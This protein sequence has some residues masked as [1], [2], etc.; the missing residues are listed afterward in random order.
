MNLIQIALFLSL[1]RLS[2]CKSLWDDEDSACQ[3]P[4]LR[5]SHIN[6]YGESRYMKVF[7][8]IHEDRTQFDLNVLLKQELGSNFLIFNMKVRVRPQ[9]GANFVTLLQMKRLDLCGF[10]TDFSGNPMIRYFL[11][12][13]MQMSKIISCPVRVGNFSVAN[14]SV[15]DIYPANLQNATYKFFVDVVEGTGEI[16]KV[17]ALQVTTDISVP[18]CRLAQE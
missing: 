2:Y 4:I 14:V 7:T 6:V 11:K 5:I 18:A 10:L 16:A 3:K 1:F 13:H 12:S 9:G 8:F 17:F 15:Y